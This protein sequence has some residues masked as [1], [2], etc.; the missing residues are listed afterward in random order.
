[1]FGNPDEFG[2]VLKWLKYYIFWKLVV[3]CYFIKNK[4]IY[5]F[6]IIRCKRYEKLGN[7]YDVNILVMIWYIKLYKRHLVKYNIIFES[8]MF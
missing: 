8:R 2:I 6:W 3:D 1:M 5:Y 4:V 7:H